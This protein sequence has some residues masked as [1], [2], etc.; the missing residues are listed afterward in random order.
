MIS[1]GMIVGLL[2]VCLGPIVVLVV[3]RY[4]V[5]SIVLEIHAL[6]DTLYMEII[7]IIVHVLGLNVDES[8][9]PTLIVAPDYKN[10]YYLI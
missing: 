6:G 1:L 3:G 2:L 10:G 8:V 7:L 9:K 4:I 5:H